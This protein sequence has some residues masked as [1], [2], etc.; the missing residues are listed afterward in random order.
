MSPK[1]KAESQAQEEA[2]QKIK[3]ERKAQKTTQP[4]QPQENEALNQPASA[5]NTTPVNMTAVF[6]GL[7]T[8]SLRKNSRDVTVYDGD[9][10]TLLVDCTKELDPRTTCYFLYKNFP[11]AGDTRLLR[12]YGIT[13]VKYMTKSGLF[14]GFAWEKEL[15]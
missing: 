10:H 15:R 3:A 13:K 2:A 11:P 12:S 8:Q 6:G 5:G 9:S 7:Y 14:S 1:Q 4:V